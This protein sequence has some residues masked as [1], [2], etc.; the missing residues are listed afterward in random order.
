MALRIHS[1]CT[2][3]ERTSLYDIYI[4]ID[5]WPAAD[6][7]NK[8]VLVAVVVVVLVG[9]WFDGSTVGSPL[10]NAATLSNRAVYIYMANQD[11]LS[12]RI[13]I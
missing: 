12:V 4:L 3:F 8:Q 6:R 11:V 2:K 1:S 9:N 13:M 7:R 5:R 10:A